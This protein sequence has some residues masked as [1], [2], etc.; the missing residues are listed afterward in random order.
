MRAMI[1]NITLIFLLLLIINVLYLPHHYYAKENDCFKQANE[2]E[3]WY[4]YLLPPE[5]SSIRESRITHIMLHFISNVKEKPHNPYQVEDI[6]Q[7]FQKHHVSSHYLIDRDGTI[8][9][10]VP[11][12]RV[13]YHAGSNL[14]H[15][16]STLGKMN[17][18]S[19]GIE[20]MAI[21]TKEE[22]TPF[23]REDIYNFI[24][25]KNIGYTDEQYNSLDKLLNNIYSRHSENLNIL[26]HNQY[27]PF[28]K[29][30]PGKLFDWSRIEK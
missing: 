30:D 9:R 11:E 6:Y 1:R 28:R 4:D 25:W 27:A 21:G 2:N 12:Y 24:H 7:L 16:F 13:A 22:M 23:I 19:I 3:L 29:T 10:F 17:E 14:F 20:L 15:G 26:G 5:N 18:H 8:Y